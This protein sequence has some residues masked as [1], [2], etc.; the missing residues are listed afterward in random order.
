MTYYRAFIIAGTVLVLIAAAMAF[1]RGRGKFTV[2]NI[3]I[4]V[5]T[6]AAVFIL[7]KSSRERD[8]IVY[9][10][11]V[12]L[13]TAVTVTDANGTW[14]LPFSPELQIPIDYKHCGEKPLRAAGNDIEAV[15]KLKFVRAGKQGSAT[16]LLC[17]IKNTAAYPADA[18]FNY[19]GTNYCLLSTKLLY[20]N[21]FFYPEEDF[22]PQ[23]MELVLQ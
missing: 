12:Y 15:A 10:E 20:K 7:M 8:D 6:T 18:V 4:I 19:Q 1:N 11:R 13:C 23:L 9:Y 16:L 17:T 22:V 5:L 21:A 3:V 2:W 14:T